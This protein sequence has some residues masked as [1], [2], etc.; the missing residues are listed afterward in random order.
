MKKAL[1]YRIIHELK[2]A[3]DHYKDKPFPET[4]EKYN[5]KDKL[6]R[7]SVNELLKLLTTFAHHNGFLDGVDRMSKGFD[8]ILKKGKD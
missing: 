2:K 4:L 6:F 8:E 5:D 3:K 1:V 7:L